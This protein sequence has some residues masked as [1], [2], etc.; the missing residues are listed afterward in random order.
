MIIKKQLTLPTRQYY[1]KH[2]TIVNVFLP[3]NLTPKEIEV[4]AVFMSFEGS[5][6]T[7]RFG[8]SARKM[9]REE[10]G[11]SSGGLG[12]YLRSLIDKGFLKE[13][14]KNNFIILPV[15]YPSEN[16]QEYLFQL[17]KIV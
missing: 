4:L 5:I 6:A 7:D 2:L 11:I 14:G 13:D 10:L 15:L 12:N 16:R 8:T 3:V 1:E 17:N 9:V